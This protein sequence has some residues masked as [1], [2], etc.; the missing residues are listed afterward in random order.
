MK[1][2]KRLM[3]AGVMLVMT[4]LLVACGKTSMTGTWNTDGDQDQE[5]FTFNDDGTGTMNLGDDISVNITYKTDGD[6]LTITTSFLGTSE[7]EDYTYKIKGK[8][9]TLTKDDETVELKKN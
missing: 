1:K 4:C 7:S 8:T 9:L 5:S 6:K 2:M 3:V